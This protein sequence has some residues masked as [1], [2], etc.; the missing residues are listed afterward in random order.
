MYLFVKHS[1][2]LIA[3]L[4][5]CSIEYVNAQKIK[6]IN[7]T[8]LDFNS[9]EIDF[10]RIEGRHTDEYGIPRIYESARN[11]RDTIPYAAEISLQTGVCNLI[12][13]AQDSVLIIYGVDAERTE[14]LVLNRDN[15]TI[16]INAPRLHISMGVVLYFNF[17]NSSDYTIYNIYPE[18]SN[19]RKLF[20]GILYG[21]DQR[22]LSREQRKVFIEQLGAEPEYY[23]S[24]T[25]SFKIIARDRN[26]NLKKGNITETDLSVENINISNSDFDD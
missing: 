15:G 22:L 8:S 3:L 5:F 12:F 21:T 4:I 1:C 25:I 11:I 2:I 10:E 24:Q 9:I 6:I 20:D 14:K 7:E 18:F 13:V 16:R 19:G 23:M 26:G 17:I